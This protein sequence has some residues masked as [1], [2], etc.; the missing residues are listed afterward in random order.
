MT[1][2]KPAASSSSASATRRRDVL[3][4]AAGAMLP[5]LA[6]AQGRSYTIVVPF[7]AGGGTDLIARSVGRHLGTRLAAPVVIDNRAGA[8]GLIGASAL[9]QA[10]PDGYTLFLSSNSV[11]TINPALRSS[12]PYDPGSSFAGLAVLGTAPLAIL[13]KA[14]A[15]WQSLKDVVAAARRRPGEL[16]YASFGAGSVSHFAGELF[17]SQAGLEML[18]VPFKGSAPA[19]Q[20][21]LGGQVS[22]AV[23][24][25]TAALPQ[26]K[27]GTVRCLAVTS[28]KRI[29]S[30]PD[31]PSVAEAAVPGFDFVTWVAVVARRDVSAEAQGRLRQA[32]QA[33][34]ATPQLVRELEQH[35]LVVRGANALRFD[36]LVAAEIPRYRATAARAGIKVE[37]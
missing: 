21:L 17:R 14:D 11:F 9:L 12:L 22:L 37:Q 30:L 1:H 10:P 32:L 5:S 19:M 16:T 7:P 35:G 29:D 25:V 28:G 31:V 20:G 3:V 26:L 6:S 33:A 27:G 18:H 23:D 2:P 4:A 13:V 15:P 8:G 36:D 34:L 24:T